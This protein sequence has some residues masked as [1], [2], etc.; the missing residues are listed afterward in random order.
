MRR[1]LSACTF[2]RYLSAKGFV[3][4]DLAARN[5]LVDADD[6]G[7][8]ADFGLSREADNDEYYVASGGKVPIRCVGARPRSVA[9]QA[10]EPFRDVHVKC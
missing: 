1:N 4:R 10:M 3:H 8:I 9:S 5:V 2:R 6:N 7:K